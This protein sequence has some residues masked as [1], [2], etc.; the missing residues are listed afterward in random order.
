[1]NSKGFTLTELLAS[2]AILGLISSI[3]AFS[4][5]KIMKENKVKQCKQKIMYIEK[6]AIN[7]VSDSHIMHVSNEM[8]PSFEEIII[9]MTNEGY[10]TE[11]DI[12]NPLTDKAFK[13]GNLKLTK[14]NG[15]ID[16]KYVGDECN[17]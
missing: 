17:E 2:I 11:E 10:L 12:I 5:T 14:S 1:M 9:S 4:Y 6:Q 8:N 15:L 7:Y 13:L 3:V 16:V